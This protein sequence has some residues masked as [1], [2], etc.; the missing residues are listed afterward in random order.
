M[1][2]LPRRFQRLQQV[3]KGRMADLTVLMERVEHFHRN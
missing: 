3:L 2:L 1:P